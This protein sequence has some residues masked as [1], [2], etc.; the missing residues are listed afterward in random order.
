MGELH[1]GYQKGNTLAFHG[2]QSGRSNR[3]IDEG[4]ASGLSITYGTN[5]CQYIWT[6]VTGCGEKDNSRFSCPCTTS[7][8]YPPLYFV[9]NNY[10]CESA[11]WYNVY[12]I[13]FFNDTLWDGV[14]CTD[15]CCS[16]T[17]QPWCYH[18]LN[19]TT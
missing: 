16:D 10:Y 1:R 2:S 3:T 4:Y 8:A 14:G 6:F 19:Q 15:N 13:Y 18:Q 17:T 12:G 7:N 11:S 9:G 5:P